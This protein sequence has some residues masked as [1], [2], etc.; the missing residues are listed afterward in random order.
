M[1]VILFNWKR[2][3]VPYV[4]TNRNSTELGKW[5]IISLGFFQ[6][7]VMENKTLVSALDCLYKERTT[8][9]A[10][11]NKNGMTD[12]MCLSDEAGDWRHTFLI[13]DNDTEEV[14]IHEVRN[15]PGSANR[16]IAI[17]ESKPHFGWGGNTSVLKV[18]G[19]VQ[20]R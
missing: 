18:L 16:T 2:L 4:T 11:K 17:I 8:P 3:S 5:T 9:P 6:I 13:Q 1:K 20:M 10:P 19:S 12:L 15:A 7:T 14:W